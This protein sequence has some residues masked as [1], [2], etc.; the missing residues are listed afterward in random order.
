MKGKEVTKC[1]SLCDGEAL[2]YQKTI[3]YMMEEGI[4]VNPESFKKVLD[5]LENM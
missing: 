2:K 1:L 5:T 4:K 3:S